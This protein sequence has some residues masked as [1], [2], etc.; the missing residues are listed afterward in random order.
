MSQM[1]DNGAE[2]EKDNFFDVCRIKDSQTGA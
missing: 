1:R 2:N